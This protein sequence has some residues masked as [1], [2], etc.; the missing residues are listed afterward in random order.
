MNDQKKTSEKLLGKGIRDPEIDLLLMEGVISLSKVVHL[1]D[2]STD[3][4][5]FVEKCKFRTFFS[6]FRK[7]TLFQFFD[8]LF[9]LKEQYFLCIS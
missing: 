2:V 7:Q 6:C 5:L 4:L 1:L 3:R 8:K 9:W